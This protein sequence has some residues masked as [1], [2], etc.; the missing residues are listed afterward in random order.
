MN[1]V[2]KKNKCTG[3]MACLEVC[4]KKAIRIEDTLDAYHAVIFEDLCIHCNA[5]TRVCHNVN[6]SIEFRK[7]ISWY[8]GWS[9]NKSCRK[10]SSSGAAAYELAKGII[11][12][13][14]CVFSCLFSNG[15]FI[16]DEV[17][18]I[19]ELKRFSGSKYVKSN[20]AGVYHNI[21]KRLQ[22]GRQV[23]FIGLPCQVA[24][25]KYV[26]GDKENLYTVD[27]ICHGTPSPKIL[28]L[29]LKQYGCSLDSLKDI[30]FRVKDQFQVSD[31]VRT[32]TPKGVRDPY[33]MAFLNG[34]IY[35][36]NCYSC[37]YAK[38]ARVSDITI[39]DSW[40]SNLPLTEQ[41]KGISLLLVQ[42]E[43][44]NALIRETAIQLYS[45]NLEKAIEANHQL[46]H[47]SIEPKDRVLFFKGLK[48]GK[49]FNELVK[50]S[51]PKQY[52][53]QRIKAVLIKL[54][55]VE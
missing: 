44:G 8:Q 25:L 2:C 3:C 43:K 54:G 34:L 50:E 6:D 39:G 30:Q 18:T 55:I 47:P 40:K 53:K 23:L 17:S 5:C 41:R 10:N 48:E 28:D 15:R 1:T 46:Q 27:L 19:A 49:R 12:R 42:T 11:S 9:S 21:R 29:F 35:T 45:V 14:G 33:M 52:T 36:E 24:A 7:S 16:F 38:R 13:G 37:R 31:K 32:F 26:V 4:P 51:F 22:E 20:P